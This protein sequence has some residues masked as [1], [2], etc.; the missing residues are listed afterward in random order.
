[1]RK[2]ITLLIA[3]L[4]VA[5]SIAAQTAPPKDNLVYGGIQYTTKA[6][7]GEKALIMG[8]GYGWRVTGNLWQLTT[9]QI[10]TT[11]YVAAEP[12]L[13]WVFPLTG[14]E[15]GTKLRGALIGGV[16]GDW[17]QF[18]DTASYRAYLP[19]AVGAS[20]FVEFPSGAGFVL[21]GREKFSFSTGTMYQDGFIF[22]FSVTKRF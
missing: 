4:L 3:S 21:A 20:L 13:A 7:L 1:M 15:G 22:N 18:A 17:L 6:A 8:G 2:T 9:G 10:G 16:S 11:G 5:G 14:K 12:V 19:G